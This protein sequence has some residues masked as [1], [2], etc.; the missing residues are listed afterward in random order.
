VENVGDIISM[1]DKN[2]KVIYV[3]PALEKVTGF[4]EKDMKGKEGFTIMHPDYQEESKRILEEVLLKPGVTIPRVSRFLHKKGHYVWVEGTV[5]NLLDDEA[6]GA[7]VSNYRDISKRKE[8]EEKV[9]RNEKRYRSIVENGADVVVILSSEGNP[10]YVSPNVERVLGYGEEEALK[11]NMFEIIYPEDIPQVMKVL[12]TALLNPGIS[13]PGYTGRMRHKDG[14]WRWYESTVTNMLHDPYIN[15]IIDNFR[16]VTERKIGEE[17]REFDS[18]N[19]K[20]LINNTND[21]MWSVDRDFKL[22]TSNHAFNELVKMMSGFEIYTGC[23]VLKT[24]FSVEQNKRF[25]ELYERAFLGQSFT[26]IEYTNV[27]S[28]FWS[29]IS[30]YPIQKGDEIIGTACFSHNITERKIFERELEK[31]TNELIATKN[32]LEYNESRL[33]QAQTIAHVGNWE[34]NFE[35]NISVWSDEAYSIYGLSPHEN[36]LSYESWLSFIHPEDLAAVKKEIRKARISLADITFY[37]RIIRKDG[38]VRHILS[39][40]KFEFNSEGH[41]IGLYGIVRDITE[42]KLAEEKLLRSEK[43][44]KTIASSISGSVI[45]MIDLDYNYLFV[46]GDMLEKFGYAKDKLLGSNAKKVSVG[47]RFNITQNDLERVLGGQYFAIESVLNGYDVIT[48]FIPL[49]DESNKVYAALMVTIDITQVKKSQHEIAEL[50]HELENK[51]IDRTSQLEN[52]NKELESFSYS[53][54]HD[55][56]SPLRAVNG[57]T[58]ILH[59]EYSDKLDEEGNRLLDKILSNTKRM[60]E[61]IDELLAFSRLGKKKITKNDFSMNEMVISVIEELKNLEGIRDIEIELTELP[62]IYADHSTIRQVWINLISNAFKY[63]QLKP[64]AVIKIGSEVIEDE[65]IYYIKDNGAGF[66]MTYKDKLFGVFQR[67]HSEEEFEGIGVGLAIVKRIVLKHD[68][69]IWAEGKQ[70]EGATFYFSL[71]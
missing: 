56:R 51:V 25:R 12:E 14:S 37:H 27:P 32:A 9:E 49:H 3:S 50:N 17:L 33:K 61:L 60:G 11:I 59:S 62:D 55:L 66:D 48:K 41:P 7:I 57:Y 16:E 46:E 6:I 35:T 43:I 40:N 70:D 22:I 26:I 5:T 67:L 52:A 19:L 29:E 24:G 4:S 38:A 58:K 53:V 64:K 44:Y 10:I 1:V 68:G 15:G 18:N 42:K 8:A 20:A 69:R 34:L 21:L 39:E 2:G 54:S 45:Y 47:E 71:N 30:F 13:I 63:T 28:D 65:L 36:E 23:D 31:N